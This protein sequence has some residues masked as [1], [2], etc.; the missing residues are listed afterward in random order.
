G[1]VIRGDPAEIGAAAR[2]AAHFVA[3]GPAFAAEALDYSV[4]AAQEATARLGH[5]EAVRHYE[6]ALRL[7]GDDVKR[8]V[9]LLFALAG[10]CDR[11]GDS[12]AARSAYRRVAD[13]AGSSADWITLARAGL[14][15]HSL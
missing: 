2:L 4:L 11:A 8:R 5:A 10:A 14:G 12:A 1:G 7:V 9:D 15:L 13:T 6:A 3:A